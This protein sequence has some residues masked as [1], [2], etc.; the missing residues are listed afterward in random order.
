MKL[1]QLILV[2]LWVLCFVPVWG[3]V[4]VFAP[5]VLSPP[6]PSW[7][8]FVLLVSPGFIALPGSVAM[9]VARWKENV[10]WQKRMSVML[11]VFPVLSLGLLFL[12]G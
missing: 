11:I 3:F 9:W 12:P 6:N 8:A 10:S 2:Q 5:M 4:I 1:W 7:L